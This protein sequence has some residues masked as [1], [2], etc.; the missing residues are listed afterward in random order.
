MPIL[1]KNDQRILFSHIPKTAGTS[2]YVW[3][4]DNGWLI[5]N[6]ALIK[7]LG[8]G[9][10]FN[11]RYGITQCQME[12]TLPDSV[13]P[14]HAVA[15]DM[16]NWGKFT[17]EF[18]IVRHPIDRFISEL[19][20]CFPSWCQNMGMKKFNADI[21][22]QYVKLFLE[23]T[24]NNPYMPNTFRDN[25]IRPQVDFIRPGMTILH[26]EADWQTTLCQQYNLTG[27]CP[28]INQGNLPINFQSFFTKSMRRCLETFYRDDFLKLGYRYNE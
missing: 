28:Q 15:N 9:R 3:F 1:Y 2:L 8:T 7:H 21:V 14:Q 5:S 19:Q 11:K 13:S 23:Q 10:E 18:C 26:F 22:R 27:R 20:Y 17:S 12:G 24:I 25:H 4:A 6:L 16:I